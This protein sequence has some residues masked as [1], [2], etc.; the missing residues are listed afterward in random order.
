M[1]EPN[2]KCPRCGNE[3]DFSKE[4]DYNY[5]NKCNFMWRDWQ[6]PNNLWLILSRRYKKMVPPL[7]EKGWTDPEEGK[8]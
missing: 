5:C 1:D 2:M 3:T 7:W 4:E 8:E 6:D